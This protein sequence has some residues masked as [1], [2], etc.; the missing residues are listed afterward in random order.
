MISFCAP[1]PASGR[2]KSYSSNVTARLLLLAV[3]GL[4]LNS[5]SIFGQEPDD[6]FPSGTPVIL[7]SIDTLRSDR[8]PAYGYSGVQTPAIDTLR[9]DGIL[10]EHAFSPV[11]LTLPAHASL[12]TG[13]LPGSHGVR[14]NLGYRLE[15]DLQPLMQERLHRLGYSTGAAVSAFV[16]R[17]DT[18]LA[19]GFDFYDDRLV[20]AAQATS[21]EVQR[22][23]TETLAAVLPWLQSVANKP[24]LMLLHLYEPHTPYDPPEPFA[25]AYPSAYDA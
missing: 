8:L 23:G 21:A 14:D 15:N 6:T 5:P 2:T 11:P 7:I 22:S 9:G 24:F 20:A 16:L 19:R 1:S 17:S 3:A 4:V 12:L 18:G 13:Q 10:F 25:S